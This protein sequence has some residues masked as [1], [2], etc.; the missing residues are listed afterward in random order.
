MGSI[1]K[2][3]EDEQPL[4]LAHLLRLSDEDR[5]LRFCAPSGDTAL[6]LH[7]ARAA[8]RGT[9]VVGWFRDGVLRAAGE[10]AAPHG[11]A[12][13]R[14]AEVALSVEAPW[15]RLG[16]GR[17]L[18]RHLLLIARNRGIQSVYMYCL[19]ENVRMRALARG[20]SGLLE[21]RDGEVHGR[22]IAPTWRGAARVEEIVLDGYG[23]LAGA[24]AAARA[25]AAQ[26]GGRPVA[27]RGPGAPRAA[28]AAW[29]S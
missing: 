14:E 25:P 24:L 10:L 13:A 26:T 20:V 7:C 29:R 8:A 5:R 16:A 11:E 27:P 6:A 19:A 23:R 18:L 15:Q 2:L 12:G 22:V 1:R 4:L 21:L 17:R 3:T 9:L 28:A